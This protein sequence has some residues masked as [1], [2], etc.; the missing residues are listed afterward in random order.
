MGPTNRLSFPRPAA[1]GS[2]VYFA[3]EQGIPGLHSG[4]GSPENGFAPTGQLTPGLQGGIGS[5][6]NPFAAPNAVP[7]TTNK[8][9]SMI[10][11]FTCL[12][13]AAV[14]AMRTDSKRSSAPQVPQNAHPVC[15]NLR[16]IWERPERI[17]TF[18]KYVLRIAGSRHFRGKAAFSV[19]EN[20]A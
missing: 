6:L 13:S 15:H 10:F 18:R 9:P 14:A 11:A 12:S 16:P 8:N 4:I 7:N 1:S 2:A 3:V 17:I 5:P 20:Q 19:R